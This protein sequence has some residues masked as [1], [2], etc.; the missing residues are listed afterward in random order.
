MEHCLPKL[1]K[2][3]ARVSFKSDPV[4]LTV[5][6]PRT[7]SKKED[8]RSDLTQ[9]VLAI[10]RDRPHLARLDS[11]ARRGLYVP[12]REIRLPTPR[13]GLF[14][15]L[16][17]KTHPVGT[18]HDDPRLPLLIRQT[19]LSR[20]LIRSHNRQHEANLYGELSVLFPYIGGEYWTVD[21]RCGVE[22]EL[23]VL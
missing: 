18:R 6:P 1:S 20:I 4:Q 14:L 22:Y 2:S 3:S 13:R 16:P 10:R 5:N 7:N 15:P 9:A 12:P 17:H 23:G 11:L 8:L 19:L 21:G